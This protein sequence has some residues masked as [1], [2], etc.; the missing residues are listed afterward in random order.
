MDSLLKALTS[1]TTL[2]LPNRCVIQSVHFEVSPIES[3][4]CYVASKDGKRTIVKIG[5]RE[6]QLTVILRSLRRTFSVRN[7]P[8]GRRTIDSFT[9]NTDEVLRFVNDVHDINYIHREPPYVVPGLLL[10]KTVYS[11]LRKILIIRG[12]HITFLLPMIVH[13]SVT[14]I[15]NGND[16]VGMAGDVRLFSCH[17]EVFE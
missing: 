5:N 4:E 11:I 7:E 14:L 2:D 8:V 9:I 17:I 12:I 13:D 3:P 10:L 1:D 16:F 6:G 15:Q